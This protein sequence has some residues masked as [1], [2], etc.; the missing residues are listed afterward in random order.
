MRLQDPDKLKNMS[1]FHLDSGAYDTVIEARFHGAVTDNFSWVANFN[2]NL[3]GSTLGAA[4]GTV[5]GMPTGSV[6]TFATL[7]VMDLIAQYKAMDE[8][9][10]WAGRL[11]VPCD[12]FNF[13]GPFFTIP[14]NYPGFYPNGGVILPKSGPTGRD[15]GIT[16]WGNALDAKL[17][18]YAGAYGIDQGSPVSTNSAFANPYYSGRISYSLQGSEPGYFG[19]GTYYGATSVATIGLGGQYQKNGY[20]SNQDMGSVMADALVEEATSSGTFTGIAQYYHFSQ[21]TDPMTGG[22]TGSPVKDAYFIM[23]AYLTPTPVFGPG[24]LQPMVR[25]QETFNPGWTL[26]DASLA[27]VF[28]DYSG[29]LVL[30]YQHGDTGSASASNPG[31]GVV[32]NAM[33]L[34]IQLQTL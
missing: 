34:G 8:F 16:V 23:L 1:E 25:L 12:R 31:G 17:K 24:K 4:S 29:R 32:S 15:Q 20:S 33:Q 14:W 7:N 6:S 10:I 5:G 19:S 21:G 13:A 9:Q 2:T 26:F 18:Y 27:Y 30:T 22:P 11:L 3:L 28:K